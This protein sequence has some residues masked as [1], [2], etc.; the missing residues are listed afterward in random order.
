MSKKQNKPTSTGPKATKNARFYNELG[1]R[2][3]TYAAT[4]GFI[5]V[6]TDQILYIGASTDIKK[7]IGT[8]LSALRAGR[9]TSDTLQ[10]HF[11]EA[12]EDGVRVVVIAKLEGEINLA[13]LA[14]LENFLLQSKLSKGNTVTKSFPGAFANKGR[15]REI[16]EQDVAEI[17][18]MLDEKIP[19]KTI[20]RVK[21]RSQS[22]VSK[23]K[24]GLYNN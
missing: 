9:H 22:V 8:N 1:L 12:G 15:D 6:L 20:A 17:L 23:I 4:Y 3:V 2:D 7:R 11:N 21:G 18:A 14:Q 13:Q 10:T 5:D 16:T 24:S 19:Q